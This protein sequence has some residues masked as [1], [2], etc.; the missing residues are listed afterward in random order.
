MMQDIF[1]GA[2]IGQPGLKFNRMTGDQ[3]DYVAL[4]STGFI[5]L[6]SVFN[7]AGR[8]FWSSLSDKLRRKMTYFVLFGLGA[9]LYSSIPWA[10]SVES[11]ALF[12]I[13][14]FII[15]SMYGG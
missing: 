11:C 13:F 8:F 3:K 7:I 10:A 9:I 4:V 15:L 1:A 12:V 5:G 2:M 6:L 14:F